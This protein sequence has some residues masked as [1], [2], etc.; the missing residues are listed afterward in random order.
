MALIAG[1]NDKELSYNSVEITQ[2][3]CFRM[4]A[5]QE[6]GPGSVGCYGAESGP[7]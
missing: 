7:L 2:I 4:S 3:S 6:F 1:L 5:A